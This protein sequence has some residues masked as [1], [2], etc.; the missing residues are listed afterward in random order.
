[1]KD[2]ERICHDQGLDH[3]DG[4]GGTW[5]EGEVCDGTTCGGG[6]FCGD[7]NLDPGEECDDG[8]NDDGDGC[9]ADCMTERGGGD[10]C[11]PGFWQ[12]VPHF[13]SWVNYDPNDL[14]SDVFGVGAARTLIDVLHR[15]MAR[16]PA[17]GK[18]AVA[19]LL[20]AASPDVD[21]FYSEAEVIALVQDAFASGDFRGVKDLFADQNELGCPI[22]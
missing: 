14:F 15:G 4:V 11:T 10:G 18:H 5:R 12:A 21:Y 19:A 2:N 16:P 7:G 9:S 22:D 3:C 1:M 8:N 6:P 13:D 17:F 20:N